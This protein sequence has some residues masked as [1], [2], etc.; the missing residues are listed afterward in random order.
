MMGS[1]RVERHDGK[2]LTGNWDTIPSRI[3]GSFEECNHEWLP[4]SK[5]DGHAPSDRGDYPQAVRGG[6]P[7]GRKAVRVL[8]SPRFPVRGRLGFQFA[9]TIDDRLG[10]NSL[11]ECRPE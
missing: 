4:R 8:S 3:I 1:D 7:I 5:S 10:G 9:Y 11:K 6:G 2:R